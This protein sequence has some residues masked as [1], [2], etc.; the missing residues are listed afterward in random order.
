MVDP[1]RYFGVRGFCNPLTLA[2]ILIRVSLRFLF[3]RENR[4]KILKAANLETLEEFLK[5]IHFPEYIA[6][7]L[8]VKETEA[9]IQRNIF[10]HEPQVSSF[11]INKKGSIFVD[12]GANVG[13]YS[14]LLHNNYET[15]L[16]VEPHPEN[17]KIMGII[18]TENNY[19]KVKICPFA[20][21][22]KDDNGV[23]LYLG[24]HCGGHSLLPSSRF[25][26]KPSLNYITVKAIT[27][28]FLLGTYSNVDLVKVDVEGAEWKVLDG[29][30]DVMNKINA[31]LIELHDL[32]RKTELENLMKAFNYKVKWVD[33]KHVYAWR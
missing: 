22:D 20:I 5:R 13:Y 9:R 33:S 31:W 26:Q 8:L 29:A 27:L 2:Y 16:A 17:V 19:S 30:K 11:I 7:I 10:R 24:S 12:I 18:K 28:D 15:I 3:G 6:Y 32:T 25:I 21:G 4:N 23:K 1:L 14:F